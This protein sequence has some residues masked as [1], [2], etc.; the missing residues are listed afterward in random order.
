MCT[1]TAQHPINAQTIPMETI[2]ERLF[3]V[4]FSWKA[5]D[6]WLDN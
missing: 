4:T 3:S 1:T 2:E 5:R 6:Y